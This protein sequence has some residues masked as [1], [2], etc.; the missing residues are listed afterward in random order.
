M[1]T[2]TLTLDGDPTELK[3]QF[4]FALLDLYFPIDYW[5]AKA[6]FFLQ[7]LKMEASPTLMPL[8]LFAC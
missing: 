8:L 2:V 3:C 7:F 5:I 4:D 1:Y 6:I